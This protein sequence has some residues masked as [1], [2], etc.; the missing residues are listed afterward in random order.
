MSSEPRSPPPRPI[1]AHLSAAGAL[2]LLVFFTCAGT[3][4]LDRWSRSTLTTPEERQTVE[5][6][7]GPLAP[8]V[9]A[10]A[11]LN[12]ELRLPLEE[13]FSPLERL[14]R[15]GQSWHVYAGGSLRVRHL[16]VWIDGGLRYRTRDAR[17]D[18]RARQLEQRRVRPIMDTLATKP[19]AFNWKGLGRWIVREALSDHPDATEVIVLSTI[20]R[21]GRWRAR[22]AHGRRATSPDWELTSV[23]PSELPDSH[24]PDGPLGGPP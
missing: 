14:F 17:F 23:D 15:I 9:F 24:A 5:A 13:A 22:P 4:G 18:W 21:F 7:T 16:E 2:V 8:A 20:G 6:Q 12:R 3:P 19:E 1:R 10:L 11:A